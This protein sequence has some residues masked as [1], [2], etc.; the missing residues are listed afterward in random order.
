MSVSMAQRR[1]PAA[2]TALL[3]ANVGLLRSPRTRQ[4]LEHVGGAL[5][6]AGDAE[7]Y[8]IVDGVPVLID[9]EES[10]V[11]G[12]VEGRGPASPIER[13]RRRG[14]SAFVKRLLSPTKRE[15]VEDIGLFVEAL[16]QGSPA[17]LVLVIGGGTEGQGTAA[18]YRDSAIR[19]LSFDI[20][21]SPGIDMVA[22][23][24]KIPLS[25]GSIDGVLVQAVLEH[26]L[27]P[28]RVVAEIWRVLKPGGIVYAE[29]PFLQQVREAAY[30]FTRFTDSGHRY[31]FRRFALIRSGPSGGAGTQLL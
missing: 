28:E 15:T 23:A 27:E 22:D 31:L 29:T 13:R 6:T 2:M 14:I 5:V 7:R 4:P 12:L 16:K 25:G 19:R 8:P 10:I 1:E 11:S 3:E 20:Y 17:P 30:D 26:V 21:H 9:V 18:L 24:H